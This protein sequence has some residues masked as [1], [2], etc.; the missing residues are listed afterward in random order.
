M[1]YHFGSYPIS[2]LVDLIMHRAANQPDKNIYTF[3]ENGEDLEVTLS[4][5]D[6][7]QRSK[8]IGAMLQSKYR[9]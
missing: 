6:L 1:T 4:Y 3:L 2:T 8:A 5:H 7:D 9:P